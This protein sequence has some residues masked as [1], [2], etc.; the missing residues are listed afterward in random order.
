V[1]S[2]NQQESTASSPTPCSS[3]SVHLSNG[4]VSGIGNASSNHCN[5]SITKNGAPNTN[6]T[7][8]CETVSSSSVIK[9]SSS[10]GN[11]SSISCSNN[12]IEDNANPIQGSSASNT[13]VY[14]PKFRISVETESTTSS[15]SE[16][17]VNGSSTSPSS[18]SPISH[19]KDEESAPSS[20][21]SSSSSGVSVEPGKIAKG[22]RLD[23]Q[24][25]DDH[26]SKLIDKNQS[27]LEWPEHFTKKL[28]SHT[29]RNSSSSHNNHHNHQRTNQV[30]IMS[31][32]TTEL[33][34]CSSSMGS[35]SSHHHR[36]A[37]GL[38]RHSSYDMN[39]S[40]GTVEFLT[41]PLI[42][43]A[44]NEL[45]NCGAFSQVVQNV[46]A[47]FSSS[48]RPS[49]AE[50]S[51]LPLATAA[52]ASLIVPKKRRRLSP[53]PSRLCGGEVSELPVNEAASSKNYY[54]D[55]DMTVRVSNCSGAKVTIR[56]N[57]GNTNGGSIQSA[58]TFG[59]LIDKVPSPIAIN[60]GNSSSLFYSPN[61]APVTCLEMNHHK[62]VGQQQQ[63]IT[64]EPLIMDN[65]SSSVTKRPGKRKAP[66]SKIP[67][68]TLEPLPFRLGT[69]APP[70]SSDKKNEMKEPTGI[71]RER[72]LNL[73]LSRNSG[74]TTTTLLEKPTV[75]L[76]QGKETKKTA[77]EKVQS[78][79]PPPS[80]ETLLQVRQQS[81]TNP[82]RPNFLA[83]KPV[84][85]APKKI[86]VGV[87]PSP[88]TPRVAKSYNQMFI[89]GMIIFKN[90]F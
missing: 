30:A 46:A 16:A 51:A 11:Q 26:I 23:R 41:N 48:I 3:K 34:P 66:S 29:S 78:K 45:L 42:L 9:P 85:S 6:V 40:G 65:D 17:P 89:N 12:A 27:I 15:V 87:L 81:S 1:V 4:L 83:L 25:L 82:K 80:D 73:S 21:K 20:R 69:T 84:N 70:L 36:I 44:Q 58:V 35:S 32:G 71:S 50:L 64:C 49:I 55:V 67:D 14:K 74:S 24:S 18:C 31:G 7:V 79:L 76:Q 43:K 90:N 52:A 88:E 38:V 54:Q 2:D 47:D 72:N 60:A 68:V 37:N 28:K 75:V 63:S 62:P 86:D 56:T 77:E 8:T 57:N 19:I 53:T 39:S 59:R 13:M 22:L 61:K 10:L 5:A 33:H